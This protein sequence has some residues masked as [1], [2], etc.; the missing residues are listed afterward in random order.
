MLIDYTYFQQG[1]LYIP[2]VRSK[3]AGEVGGENLTKVN[4]FIDKYER[5]LLMNALGITLYDQLVA[6]VNANQLLDAGNEHWNALVNGENYVVDGE[7]YRFDG[8]LGYNKQSMIAYYV[9]CKYLRENDVVYTTT[10]TV[11]DTSKNAT[12]VAATPKYVDIWNFFVNAYQGK[13]YNQDFIDTPSIIRNSGGLI[14]LTWFAEEGITRSLY[15]F[16]YDKNDADPTRFTDF[17]FKFYKR[18]NSMGI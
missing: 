3:N 12:S 4:L 5:E 6:I 18:E 8:L 14:G 15:Q 9:F 13:H 1:E 10:G 2:N 7:T 16:L 17:K 11:K